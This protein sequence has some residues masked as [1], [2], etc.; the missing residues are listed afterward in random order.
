MFVFW[1]LRFLIVGG[2][3]GLLDR[4]YAVQAEAI[5]SGKI[6][7]AAEL[8]VQISEI[9]PTDALFESSFAEARVSQVRLARY[10]LRALELKC[11]GQLEAELIPSDDERVI[12]LEHILP[13]NPGTSWPS[14]DDETASAFWRRIGNMVILQAKKNSA[15]GNGP[16][17]EKKA[18]FAESAFFLTK[19]VAKYNAWG[20][21]EIAARQ[22]ELA[23][24]AVETWPRQ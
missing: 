5:G 3:G 16:F 11:M 15:I 8:V 2:R 19:D 13:H 17:S 1:S 7:T 22:R 4:N 24:L 20:P 9:I 21:G 23:K 12:N 14:I 18:V 6:K 10:Y